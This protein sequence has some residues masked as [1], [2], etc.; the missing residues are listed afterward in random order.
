MNSSRELARHHC[1]HFN[2]QPIKV[3]TNFSQFIFIVFLRCFY[4]MLS[5]SRCVLL[6]SL[7]LYFY[8]FRVLART[9]ILWCGRVYPFGLDLCIS[10]DWLTGFV[11]MF[12]E[13]VEIYKN[14]ETKS[15]HCC[16]VCF[17]DVIHSGVP[18]HRSFITHRHKS[19]LHLLT[20]KNHDVNG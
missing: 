5:V 14:T 18:R 4:S 11:L 8:L 2:D 17:A 19:K 15:N 3:A 12:A 1:R 16:F 6:V 9:G 10:V 13:H 20:V 7:S